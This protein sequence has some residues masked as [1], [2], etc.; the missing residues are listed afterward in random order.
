MTADDV[1]RDGE[2]VLLC[3][4]CQHRARFA[5]SVTWLLHDQ[6]RA[7]TGKQCH[8]RLIWRQKG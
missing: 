8:A 4:S 6:I 3:H 5:G 7:M 2:A 1:P